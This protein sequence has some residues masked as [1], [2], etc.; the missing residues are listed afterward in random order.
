MAKWM[1]L[2]WRG[3][4][5]GGAARALGGGYL[6]ATLTPE[7]PPRAEALKLLRKAKGG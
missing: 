3:G 4:R 7:D 1:G 6:T 5:N 2:S